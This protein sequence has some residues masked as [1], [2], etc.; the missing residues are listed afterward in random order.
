VAYFANAQT[1]TEVVD[2]QTPY[3]ISET[4]IEWPSQKI[5]SSCVLFARYYTG[6]Q[7][8]GNANMLIPD[9]FSN[10][11]IGD[12]VLFGNHVA[13]VTDVQDN[14]LSL[15][16]SNYVSGIISNRTIDVKDSNIL[17]YK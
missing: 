2:T 1:L 12:W 8:F 11:Q 4:R 3:L 9:K 14:Q 17:G 10:P 6:K 5:L 16:E 15:I 13:V 7:I